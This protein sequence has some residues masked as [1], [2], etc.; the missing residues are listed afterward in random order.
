MKSWR[1]LAMAA[2]AARAV[3]QTSL[4]EAATNRVDVIMLGDSNQLFGGVGYDAGWSRALSRR[5]GLY[6]T[7]VHWFGENAG[8]G[9]GVGDG[10]NTIANRS[11]G[12]FQ[13]GDSPIQPDPLNPHG[14]DLEPCS[15]IMLLSDSTL[16]S[17]GMTLHPNSP[18]YHIGDRLEFQCWYRTLGSGAILQPQVRLG[19]SPWTV[20]AQTPAIFHAEGV[21][22]AGLSITAW[23]NEPMDFRVGNFTVAPYEVYYGLATNADR[24]SGASVTTLYGN[25]GRS[26]RDCAASVRGVQTQVLAGV[27]GA[28]RERQAGERKR[29]LIRLAFGLNDVNETE[30]SVEQGFPG[31]SPEA[32]VDNLQAIMARI[33]DVVLLQGWSLDEVQYVISTP[34]SISTP[35]SVV[36]SEYAAA[37]RGA[38]A[39]DRVRV[40]W[41]SDFASEHVMLERGYYASSTDR[42]HLSVAGY[43]A[44]SD[45]EIRM[46]LTGGCEADITEDGGVD[47][48]DVIAF[49]GLWDANLMSADFNRDGG[50]DG[51]D[52]IAFFV[53]WDAGC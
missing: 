53:R 30:P 43:E 7:G 35:Q 47:G 22:Q 49:F 52:V 32:Y 9:A 50:V 51:D 28:V 15:V 31:P 3:A 29:L 37:A 27:L 17:V 12:V 24:S 48:D 19:R 42:D 39:S 20:M 45:W 21:R 11:A 25:G 40:L 34:H 8:A 13:Y 41:L 5:F 36:L 26:A 18:F 23:G 44:M 46:L 1:V 2:W 33:D 4:N 10:C 16:T 14:T 38:L 6:G